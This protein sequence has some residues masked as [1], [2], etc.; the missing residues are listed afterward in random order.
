MTWIHE[1]L[2]LSHPKR[3][4]TAR[5]PSP[6]ASSYVERR[7]R[8]GSMARRGID[9]SYS[10]GV[11]PGM[12]RP[13]VIALAHAEHALWP[14]SDTPSSRPRHARSR[15]DPLTLACTWL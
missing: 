12:S 5:R 6:I 9:S 2:T 11:F 8:I 7:G 15:S 3:R 13:V 10:H 1:R 14:A 4:R